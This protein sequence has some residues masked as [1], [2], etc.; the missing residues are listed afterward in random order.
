ML[1]ITVT[2]AAYP[3]LGDHYSTR[4]I[5]REALRVQERGE[6]IVTYRFFHHTLYYYTG[7][8]VAEDFQDSASL[9]RFLAGHPRML[10]VTEQTRI[11][12]LQ[13]INGVSLTELASQSNFRLLRISKGPPAP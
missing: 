13:S 8:R 12:E 6:P 11:P 5:A 9:S 1:L 3:V 4:G 10:V 7:Y 2:V